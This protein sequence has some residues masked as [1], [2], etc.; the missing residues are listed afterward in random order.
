MVDV[1]TGDEDDESPRTILITLFGEEAD[2]EWLE[3]IERI[4]S[5][6]AEAGYEDVEVQVGS[7]HRWLKG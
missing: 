1:G 2:A 6:C 5:V 4:K 7:G 3:R